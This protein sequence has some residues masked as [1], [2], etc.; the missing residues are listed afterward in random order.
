MIFLMGLSGVASIVHP[1]DAGEAGRATRP[2]DHQDLRRWITA[3]ALGCS[4]YGASRQVEQAVERFVG[5]NCHDLGGGR[6]ASYCVSHPPLEPRPTGALA[7]AGDREG[8]RRRSRPVWGRQLP[9][10]DAADTCPKVRRPTD[11][12]RIDVEWCL[13]EPSGVVGNESERTE[14]DLAALDQ[15]SARNHDEGNRNNCNFSK[16]R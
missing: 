11:G 4:L 13:L 9:Q 6:L 10:Q 5:L 7:L 12:E 16:N 3:V 2:I 14:T 1:V 15:N 8:G